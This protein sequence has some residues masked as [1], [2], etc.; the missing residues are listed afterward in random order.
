MVFQL[1]LPAELMPLSLSSEKT[2]TCRVR[3][4]NDRQ[5]LRREPG[6]PG[7]RFRQRGLLLLERQ[8]SEADVQ[9]GGLGQRLGGRFL[10]VAQFEQYAERALEFVALHR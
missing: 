5:E 10:A 6:G 2:P 4:I 9:A 3:R 1:A 7:D 8:Q